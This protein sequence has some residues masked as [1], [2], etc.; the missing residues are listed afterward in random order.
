[1][2]RRGGAVI[3]ETGLIAS[4]PGICI[5]NNHISDLGGWTAFSL[6][7]PPFYFGA[8]DMNVFRNVRRAAMGAG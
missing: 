7:D 2:A 3:G 5:S 6:N 1:M 8:R 4:W